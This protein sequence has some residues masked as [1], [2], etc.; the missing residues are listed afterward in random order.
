MENGR[1]ANYVNRAWERR[2][3]SNCTVNYNACGRNRN[4]VKRFNC[5]ELPVNDIRA[6]LFVRIDCCLQ[7]NEVLTATVVNITVLLDFW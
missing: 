3:F 5:F 1:Y 2:S 7:Q 4:R 6:S